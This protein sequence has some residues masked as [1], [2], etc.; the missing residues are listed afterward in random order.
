MNKIKV[1]RQMGISSL[2]VLLL[3]GM[4][5]EERL[6]GN[7]FKKVI[8]DF[9]PI[10]G[11][12]IFVRKVDMEIIK[13]VQAKEHIA[14]ILR[15][16]IL[17]NRFHDGAELVQEIVSEQLG[18]SRMPVREAFQILELEGFLIRLPNR[19]M[20]VKGIT[21]KSIYEIFLFIHSIQ[22]GFIKEMFLREEDWFGKFQ[23]MRQMFLRHEIDEIML[24]SFF[25][26]ELDSGYLQRLHN[27]LLQIYMAFVLDDLEVS[28]AEEL[29]IWE[30]VE[31]A[32]SQKDG[33]Q[34]GK[35]FESYFLYLAKAMTEKVLIN[36]SK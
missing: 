14:D 2:P 10:N 17:F 7:A 35:L 31:K 5:K 24:H 23:Q 25:S 29:N 11:Y 30:D 8:V 27:N 18:V 34:A 28:G 9:K 16:E 4:K 13:K 33:E 32:L 36:E 22:A 21:E 1:D 26:E 6:V 20:V 19:H 3:F 12:N 15:K